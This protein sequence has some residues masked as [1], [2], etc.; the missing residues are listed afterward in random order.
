MTN[1]VSTTVLEALKRQRIE[2]PS[3]GYGNSGTR[4]KTFPAPGAA[5]TVWEKLEDAGEVNRLTGIAPSVALH[6]PWDKPDDWSNLSSFANDHHIQIG[7]IN[8]NVFQDE[9]CK[10]RV[11][12]GVT[13]KI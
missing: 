8:P 3:W 1:Q 5:R 13:D 11:L 4:F 12:A 2:T 6:I 7:A 10:R 9:D